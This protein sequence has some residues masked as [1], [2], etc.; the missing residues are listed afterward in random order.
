MGVMKVQGGLSLLQFRNEGKE[1]RKEPTGTCFPAD[2]ELFKIH[3]VAKLGC[4]KVQHNESTAK[5]IRP[6]ATG[7]NLK[8][9]KAPELIL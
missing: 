6:K 1:P 2:G 9:A 5:G 8:G 3:R 4:Q 7:D